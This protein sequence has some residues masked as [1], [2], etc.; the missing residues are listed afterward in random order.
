M[1]KPDENGAAGF[2]LPAAAPSDPE[3]AKPPH[4]VSNPPTYSVL[5]PAIAAPVSSNPDDPIAAALAI[6]N[7]MVP[8]M[9]TSTFKGYDTLIAFG[10]SNIDALIQANQVFAKAAEEIGKEIAALAQAELERVAAASRE[11]LAAKSVEEVLKVQTAFATASF[12][13][14]LATSAK[15]GELN[16]KLATD[17]VVPITTKVSTALEKVTTRAA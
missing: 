12:K 15:L 1:A 3:A 4:A 6:F 11:A 8:I 14:L 5:Q 13:R 2:E 16:I 10:Q 9:T 7:W 17:T